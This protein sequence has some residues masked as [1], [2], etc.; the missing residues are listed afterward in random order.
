MIKYSEAYWADV[1]RILDVVTDLEV[2]AGHTV[3]ITGGTGMICSAVVEILFRY[4][5]F[6]GQNPIKIILAGRSKE[7]IA[8]R[9]TG[10]QEGIDYFFVA[11]DATVG[12]MPEVDVQYIIH[13]AS[14]ANPAAY[15]SEPVETILAN[16]IGLNALLAVAVKKHCKRLIYL[17]S[18]EVYGRKTDA[19]PF[20]EEDYGFVDILNPR[21]SYPCSKRAAENLCVSY[22]QEYG[23]E[24]VIV[25]PGHIYGPS[26]TDSDSRAS[27]QFTRNACCGEDIIMKS[28]G[29]QLRSYCYTLDCA[30]AILTVLLNGKCG[31]AYNISNKNSIVTIRDIAE[32]LAQAAGSKIKFENPTDL[33]RRGYNLMDNSSLDAQKLEELGWKALFDVKEGVERTVAFYG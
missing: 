33:E 16:V 11:Y 27:A 1:D 14:N 7:R 32:A 23:L 26:I 15:A 31:E 19:R 25:R 3:L 2:M 8:R 10:F 29:T 12:N 9:F 24:T 18:S 22:G 20:G 17:S 28:A 30:S 4:N 13:G 21:A 5:H 6:H